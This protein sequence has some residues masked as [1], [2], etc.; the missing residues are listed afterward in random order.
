VDVYTYPV[1]I[2]VSAYEWGVGF[3]SVTID[4]QF[5]GFIYAIFIRLIL[6]ARSTA[7]VEVIVTRIEPFTGEK[8]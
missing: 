5:I 1:L 8:S 3:D 2:K 4:V 6:G 7:D